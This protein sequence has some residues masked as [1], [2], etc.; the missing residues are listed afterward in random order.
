MA[1]SDVV[2]K[3]VLEHPLAPY[4]VAVGLIGVGLYMWDRLSRSPKPPKIQFGVTSSNAT[5][6]SSAFLVL[7]EKSQ[8]PKLRLMSYKWLF[9]LFPFLIFE[10]SWFLT[11]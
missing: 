1:S 6:D 10:I 2:S 4:A 5:K 11:K 3:S 8:I 9:P 7:L